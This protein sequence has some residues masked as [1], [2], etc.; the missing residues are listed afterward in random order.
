MLALVASAALIAYLLVPGFLFKFIFSWF[1]P[2]EKFRRN[3]TEELTFGAFTTLL[4]LTVT[5]LLVL[6]VARF[7]NHPYTFPDSSALVSSDY[8]TATASIYSENYFSAHQRDFWDSSARIAWRQTRALTWLYLFTAIEAFLFGWL[9]KNFGR[10]RRFRVYAILAERLLIPNISGWYVLLT[11]FMWPRKPERKV[12]ADLLTSDDHLY[13]GH[14][15]GYEVNEEGDL[16]GILLN[17]ALRFDRPTYLKDKDSKPSPRKEA[18][19][20]Q[21]PGKNLFVFADK[22]TTMNL[23]YLAPPSSI[24][25]FLQGILKKLNIE[26]QV[27]VER[28]PQKN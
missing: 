16:R 17:E 10:F 5:F 24:P 13:R 26:A 11:S 25:G 22:I 8:Q 7:G 28:P 19:W 3:R 4:P 1:I 21:I 27:T 14:V 18:Y 15:V 20:R 9:G 2:L 12:I 6:N 23:S